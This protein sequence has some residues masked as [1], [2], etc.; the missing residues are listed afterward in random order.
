M[1]NVSNP[2]PRG[3][4]LPAKY[5]LHGQT[6]LVTGGARG[7]GA[8]IVS[9][10]TS[11][12]CRVVI[13]D[14][15]IGAA[16]SCA[17]GNVS[18]LKVDVTNPALAAAAA[19]ETRDLIGIPDIVVNNAGIQGPTVQIA[20]YD[21][22]SWERVLAVNLTAVF[23]VCKL[24]APAMKERGSGRIINIASAAGVRGLANGCAYG[25]SKAAVIGFTLGLSKELVES[26]VTV[27]C[28]APAIIETELQLQMTPEFIAQ[29]ASR[30]P[31]KRLGRAEE[32]AATVAWIA[33]PACSFTT[34]AVFD[35]AGGRLS[36]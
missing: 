7:I 18:A 35:V 25:S 32:V 4:W 24:F 26:G 8:A 5:S 23:T 21:H 14:R 30:V 20:D 16:E 6:A 12:G 15:D 1:E 10:L 17:S 3:A 9:E 22:A 13:W 36:V 2:Q 31:M 19:Q 27:N 28:V 33:S 11:L 29:A 34:G